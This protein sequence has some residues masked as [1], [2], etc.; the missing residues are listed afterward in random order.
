MNELC[1]WNKV[2]VTFMNVLLS[3]QNINYWTSS[4]LQVE[5]TYGY[6]FFLE[7][8][9]LSNWGGTKVIVGHELCFSRNKSIKHRRPDLFKSTFIAV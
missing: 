5:R 1:T 8:E 2:Y 6:A 4:I 3:L 9:V 7:H